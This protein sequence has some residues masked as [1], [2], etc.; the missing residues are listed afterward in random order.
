MCWIGRSVGAGA[1]GCGRGECAELPSGGGGVCA[2]VMN[3]LT[4]TARFIVLLKFLRMPARRSTQGNQVPENRKIRST[5][6]LYNREHKHEI[7]Y[8]MQ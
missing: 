2:V 1:G 6:L 4:L 5:R 3:D 7:N 8:D